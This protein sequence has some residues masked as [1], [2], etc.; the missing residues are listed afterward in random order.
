MTLIRKAGKTALK[1]FVRLSVSLDAISIKDYTSPMKPE[2][3]FV[4]ALVLGISGGCAIGFGLPVPAV[5]HAPVPKSNY[6]REV[7]EIGHGY[8]HL[9]IIEDRKR[10]RLCYITL[11]KY[12]REN[13]TSCGILDR[14]EAR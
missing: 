8:N 12:A 7:V 3:K 2:T 5:A 9:Y 10:N 11:S 13:S 1:R 14:N 4:L 6:T